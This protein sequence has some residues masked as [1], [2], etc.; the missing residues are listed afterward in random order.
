M[1]KQRNPLHVSKKTRLKHL[2]NLW[3]LTILTFLLGFQS[4]SAKGN[5]AQQVF[6]DLEMKNV[7][8]EQ[9]FNTIKKQSKFEFFYSN[10]QV[11]V[12]KKVSVNTR[13]ASID[14]VLDAVL[15]DQYSYKIED[16][17]ILISKKEKDQKTQ[18]QDIKQQVN[19]VTG[20]VKDNGDDPLPGVSIQVKGTTR[21]T[22]T[23]IN[24]KYTIQV[25]PEETLV[26]SYL[27]YRSQEKNVGDNKILDIMLLEDAQMIDEIVVVGFGG[28]KKANLTGAV[29]TVKMDDILGSRPVSSTAQALNGAIPGL[30]VTAT[31]GQPGVKTDL[32]IRGFGR[33]EKNTDNSAYSAKNPGPLILVDNV[34]IEDISMV[35]PND[36]ENVTVLKDAAASA[37]HGARAAFGVVLI[38]TKHGGK[39]QKAR[40]NYSN[41]FTFS[42]P[43]QLSKK[44]SALQ[45]IQGWLDAGRIASPVGGGQDLA[46]WKSLIQN[47][48]ANPSQYPNGYEVVNG[49]RYDLADTDVYKDLLDDAGFQQSHN[50]SVSGGSQKST[51]RMSF[52]YTDEDGVMITDKD[53]YKRYNASILASSDITKWMTVQGEATYSNAVQSTPNGRSNGTIWSKATSSLPTTPSGYSDYATPGEMLPIVT[54]A[55]LVEVGDVKKDRKDDLR[56]VGRMTL[57]PLEGLSVVG[58]FTYYNNRLNTTDYDKLVKMVDSDK[59][60]TAYT[61]EKGY[62]KF[63]K[64]N[65]FRDHTALNIYATYQKQIERHNFSVMGGFNQEYDYYEYLNTANTDMINSELPSISQGTGTISGRDLYQEYAVRGL[66]YRLNYDYQGKYLLEVNGRYD[67]SSKFPKDD[68]FGFFPSFSLGWRVSEE[69]FMESLKPILSNLKLRGSWGNIGNQGIDPY[70]YV[71]E[72]K[73]GYARWSNGSGTRYRTLG[74][75]NMVSDSFTW[76]RVQT[77]DF[78]ADLGFFD[79]RLNA[80]FDWYSRKTLGMLAPG[81]DFPAVVGSSSPNENSAD[82]RTN[83]W[84]LEMTWR[85]KIGKVSYHIGF[86]IFDSQTEIIKFDDNDTKLLANENLYVGKKVGEIWGLVTDRYYTE[87]DFEDYSTGKLKTGNPAMKGVARHFAGDV[88]YKDLD[89]DGQ[90]IRNY[91]DNG[92]TADEPGDYEIIGNSTPRY[93]FG[94]NGGVNWNNFDFSFFLHGVGKRD[95]SLGKNVRTEPYAADDFNCLYENLL[96]YWTPENPN[97]YY[98]RFYNN[99]GSY[100]DYNYEPQTKYLQ[101]GAFLRIKNITLGY[102]IPKRILQKASIEQLR[103]FFSGENLYTFKHTPDG[104]EPDLSGQS[105]TIT[106]YPY[107]RMFSFGLNLSF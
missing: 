59:W 35:N 61:S 74:S 49:V 97:A 60:N 79:S 71:S 33:I 83:G 70:S 104:I 5:Y 48:Q 26:F 57:Q 40:I 106:Q 76:E 3:F 34:P 95:L 10:D 37:V 42:S 102:T 11:N 90:I 64:I 45:N 39:E 14:K 9:V 22:M 30:T 16:N 8:L 107:M 92:Q 6:F 75:P 38:T 99:S 46:T 29:A 68:R 72:M 27:G 85:D 4:L 54:P 62:S 65:S 20:V 24:G 25:N 63:E 96:D 23:D 87:D 77:L 44:A 67:G 66:F 1:K 21:G 43:L 15:G 98:P 78:G 12:N 105:S 84:E 58:E 93:N 50:L 81:M 47:Y 69:A 52:G 88:L 51:Y 41:N 73:S 100:T 101:N 28:L 31:S 7:T 91:K 32:N 94:I 82:L 55:N 2:C 36:I 17:F 103:L 86:N 56:L 13:N 18:P 53:S 19:S 89:K 80:V